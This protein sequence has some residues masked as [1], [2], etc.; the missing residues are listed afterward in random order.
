GIE[1]FRTRKGTEPVPLDPTLLGI[2]REYDRALARRQGV[3]LRI[4]V[5]SPPPGEAPPHIR[6]AWVGCVLPLHTTTDDPKVSRQAKGV[7]SGRNE[8]DP[9]GFVVQVVD[10]VRELE[11]HNVEAARWWHDHAPHLVQPGELFVYPEEACALV[12]ET[13]PPG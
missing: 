3:S 11:C 2:A 4:R 13:E 1:R 12:E 7:L 9:S 10:A 8:D 6:A 5:L